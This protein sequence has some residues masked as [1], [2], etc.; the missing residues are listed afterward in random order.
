MSD[1]CIRS[2]GVCIVEE[3]NRSL[4]MG[5]MIMM[6]KKRGVAFVMRRVLFLL[7]FGSVWVELSGLASDTGDRN[8]EFFIQHTVHGSDRSIR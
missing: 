3:I 4:W 8:G 2:I 7:C 6:V 5:L 1:T